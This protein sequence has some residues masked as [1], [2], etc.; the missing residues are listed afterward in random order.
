MEEGAQ[1]GGRQATQI[2]SPHMLCTNG[3]LVQGRQVMP[4]WLIWG[5]RIPMWR[6]QGQCDNVT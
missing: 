6:L 5:Q 3:G 2:V 1:Q 4:G